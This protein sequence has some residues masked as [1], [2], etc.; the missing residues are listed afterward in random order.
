MSDH[1]FSQCVLMYV[2]IVV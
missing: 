2:C 1:L